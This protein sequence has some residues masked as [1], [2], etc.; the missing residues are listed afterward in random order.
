MKLL[1]YDDS[2][3]TYN[4]LPSDVQ[5][6]YVIDYISSNDNFSELITLEAVD[7]VWNITGNKNTYIYLR[8]QSYVKA[9]LIE[10]TVYDILFSIFI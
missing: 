3:I 10:Y 4:S 2:K 7:G 6:S 9:P 1:I 8:S 5:G